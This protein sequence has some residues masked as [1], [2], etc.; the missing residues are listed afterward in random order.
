MD[1][2][3][4]P[5]IDFIK[6]KEV[7]LDKPIVFFDLETT[8]LDTTKDRIVEIDAIKINP[9]YSTEELYHLINPEM[10]IPDEVTSVHDIADDDVRDKPTFAQVVE[11]IDNFFG[12]GKNRYDIGGFNITSFDIPVMVEEFKRVGKNFR[13]GGRKIIDAYKIL[14]KA[15][16]RDLKNV[17]KGYTGK[18][19]E[20]AHQ[21]HAD[22]AASALV[23]FNQL[24]KYGFKSIDEMFNFSHE[25]MVDAAGFFRRNKDNV[26]V[27]GIGKYKGRP[28]LDVW[29]EAQSSGDNSYFEKYIK[30]KCGSDINN[31][32]ELIINGTEK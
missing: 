18:E 15:E 13:Y 24:F 14:V 6:E 29:K 30:V 20:G 8:G 16:P 12:S 27:F 31:H 22:T 17:Y 11:E 25:G 21:A 3:L 5:V 28:V 10:H 7:K 23:A 9:D 1:K 26:I 19:L 4:Q 32:L 2:N